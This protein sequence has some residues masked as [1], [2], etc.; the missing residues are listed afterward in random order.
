MV[1]RLRMLTIA[2]KMSTVAQKG[3]PVTTLRQL[4]QRRKDTVNPDAGHRG[5]DFTDDFEKYNED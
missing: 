1:L 5:Q 4:Q 2:K 3:R